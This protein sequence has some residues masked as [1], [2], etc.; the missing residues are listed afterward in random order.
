MKNGETIRIK[1]V[2]RGHC[3]T[4]KTCG[5]MLTNPGYHRKSKYC[6]GT[7]QRWYAYS[8]E[9]V[10]IS[11]AENTYLLAIGDYSKKYKHLFSARRASK[12]IL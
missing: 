8:Y 1:M 4:C 3:L 9:P 12:N 11:R 2:E 10:T 5:K 7:L 6:C